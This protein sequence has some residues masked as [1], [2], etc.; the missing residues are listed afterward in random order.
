MPQSRFKP[1][2][3]KPRS[4]GDVFFEVLVKGENGIR[5]PAFRRWLLWKQWHRE[6][7][8]GPDE[9][10]GGGTRPCCQGAAFHHPLLPCYWFDWLVS[11]SFMGLCWMSWFHFT[12]YFEFKFFWDLLGFFF[13]FFKC[14][15]INFLFN[16]SFLYFPLYLTFFYYFLFSECNFALS[17]SVL[18]ISVIYLFC[19]FA[20][21]ALT[22]G[23]TNLLFSCLPK[24]SWALV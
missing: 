18:H 23:F 11:F 19:K 2:G 10:H 14:V 22:C 6:E 21:S 12:F 7:E 3:F 4:T 8:G 16:F 13:F 15:C 24:S 5:R 9:G 20:L 17:L 1:L